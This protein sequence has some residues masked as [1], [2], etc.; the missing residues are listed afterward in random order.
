MTQAFFDRGW[1][2]FPYDAQLARWGA[3]AKPLAEK[4]AADPMWQKDWMRC[5]GTW[6]VGVNCLPNGDDGAVNN[7]VNGVALNGDCVRF[8]KEHIEPDLTAWDKAQVSICYQGYPKPWSGESDA[9]LAY[10]RNRDAA[11]VDGLH[12]QGLDNARHLLEYHQ[13]LLGIPLSDSPAN[14]APFVVWEGSHKL[15]QAA[16]Q[17]ALLPFPV[18][19]WAQVDLT[20]T[21]QST[22]RQIFESCK[23]VELPAKPGES[24]VIHRLALHGMA[25]WP[26]DL[27]GPPE[28]RMIAYFRP[29]EE[30]SI[31]RWLM[32]P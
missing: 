6:F 32:A 27:A 29:A 30:T 7:A 8:I 19:Q 12:R 2:R 15:L 10:R 14:A 21:Y 16:F 13:F 11:H 23:R 9:A 28:G 17:Q 26:D 3:A 18:E 20:E 4:I 25:P 22:R 31:K 24:Y 5:G 1:V